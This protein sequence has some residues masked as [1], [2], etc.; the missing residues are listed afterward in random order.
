MYPTSTVA[1][2][3]AGGAQDAALLRMGKLRR[4]VADLKEQGAVGRL[5][6]LAHDVEAALHDERTSFAEAIANLPDNFALFGP[7][8]RLIICN[9]SFR[10]AFQDLPLPIE[11]GVRFEDLVRAVAHS[12]MV[13]E[14]LANPEA[15]VAERMCH[16]RSGAAVLEFALRGGGWR[17]VSERR[18]PR[19]CTVLLHT[20]TTELNTRARQLAELAQSNSRLAA[21]VSAATVGI[22]IAENR[23]INCPLTFVNEAF[24]RLT[25]YR[26]EEVLG[27]DVR[28]LQGPHTSP[29]AVARIS[30]ALRAGEPITLELVNHRKDGT[31]FWNELNISPIHDPQGRVTHFIGV[32]TDVT[33]RRKAAE[34][35]SRHIQQ[36]QQLAQAAVRINR[37]RTIRDVVRLVAEESRALVGARQSIVHLDG[38]EAAL[39]DLWA[40]AA[41]E[42]FHGDMVAVPDAEALSIAL[43]SL[44]QDTLV[45]RL[46]GGKATRDEPIAI[47]GCLV[48]AIIDR[49]LARIGAILLVDKLEG[50]FTETDEALLLQLSQTA[51]V[52]LENAL[53]YD[54]MSEAQRELSE[55]HKVARL[56]SW[57][58]ELGSRRVQWADGMYAIAG[59]DP[60]PEER[61]DAAVTACIPPRDRARLWTALEDA[62]ARGCAVQMEFSLVRP[63]G[64]TVHC[65][66]EGRCVL[67]EERRVAA[68]SGVVQDVTE[69]RVA[70]DALRQAQK[71]EAVGQ[72]TGGI[73][74]DFNNLLTVILGNTELLMEDLADD[75]LHRSMAEM[76]HSAAA[77]GADL[78]QQLLAF[79]R[80]QV[81][82]PHPVDLNRLVMRMVELLRRTLGEHIA[83]S[84]VLADAPWH[85]LADPA[86]LETAVLNLALNARDA[87]PDGGQLV[88]ET[89]NLRLAPGPGA[90]ALG[91]TAGDYVLLR[92]SDNGQGMPPEVVQRAFE[93]FFTTKEVG[94]GSGLG[95]SQVYGFAKQSG[96][97]VR[98]LSEPGRGTHIM[99]YLPRAVEAMPAGTDALAPAP[100]HAAPGGQECI[101]VVEDE[102]MVRLFVVEQL[103][104]LGYTVFEA[105][106]GDEALEELRKGLPA[107]LLFTDVVMPGTLNGPR[108]AE[109]ARELRP[110]LKVVFSSGYAEGMFGSDGCAPD[111]IYLRKPY[112]KQDLVVAVRDALSG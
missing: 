91:L 37:G 71:M 64:A 42:R 45:A 89:V 43:H 1:E 112:R 24:C 15:W 57:R 55:A 16:H 34:S 32:Q 12:G 30:D 103:R 53:L 14:A 49:R 31:P 106:D 3:E 73:A 72:L 105:A 88:I 74:H 62:A 82:A 20:D 110:Q 56:A 81:L 6:A 10:D 5:E 111:T 29:A 61:D 47:A 51:A 108:L 94:Q 23:G 26:A 96:G 8:D 97:I 28:F 69:R 19:G 98:L 35:E 86:Q 4:A 104:A 9:D 90:D 109:A 46:P 87:M 60:S 18:T 78:T 93:P 7:D 75:E 101:L 63:D 80:K 65:W 102:P 2:P 92:V 40:S 99:M 66:S 52:A 100:G 44:G 25:G 68:I 48:G 76:S 70:E 85:P 22:S 67:D 83:V 39:R 11:P 27:R 38:G 95:L 54:R 77:R 13:I 107:D 17:R 58:W 21:A 41:P 36:L 79:A 84:A 59:I 50:E 33:A